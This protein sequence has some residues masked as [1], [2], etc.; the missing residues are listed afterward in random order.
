MMNWDDLKL[1]LAVVRR[2][3]ISGAAEQLGV[4]HSTVSRRIRKLESTLGT[5]LLERKKSGLKLTLAGQNLKQSALRIE[6]EI[7]GIDATLLGKDA[8]MVGSLRVAALNNMASSVLMPIFASFNKQY[9]KVDLHIMVSNNDASLSQ[10]DADVALRLT[11]TPQETLVGKQICSVASTLYASPHYLEQHTTEGQA[12]RNAPIHQLQW[13][14][15]E[16]CAFHKM[17]TK[18]Y[19]ATQEHHFF[20][21]DTQLTQAALREGL[22]VSLLPCFMGD[23]DPELVRYCDPK[24]EWQLGLWLLL[25]PDLKHTARVLAF[26][27]HVTQNIEQQ[28]DLFAGKKPR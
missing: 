23:L 5:Q 26:R 14:G 10:R 7:L 4:Q 20:V 19:A 2:G 18:K 25:H 9:P 1:F 28:R 24:P 16:C 11:Q 8:K 12:N 13:L 17:W 6:Y 27:D 22:G 15:V 3:S 21:D